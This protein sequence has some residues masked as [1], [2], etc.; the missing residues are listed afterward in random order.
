MRPPE[1]LQ[2]PVPLPRR[3]LPPAR[4]DVKSRR[5]RGLLVNRSRRAR[6]ALRK[7][8]TGARSRLAVRGSR[9]HEGGRGE[10]ERLCYQRRS[11]RGEYCCGSHC[12]QRFRRCQR[13]KCGQ[14]C[15]H[16]GG[17]RRREGR[18]CYDIGSSQGRAY[19]LLAKGQGQGVRES[20][21]SLW[22]DLRV[23]VF[24]FPRKAE[25]FLL[26]LSGIR[27]VHNRCNDLVCVPIM[28]P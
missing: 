4:E 15:E 12:G 14:V 1:R 2:L 6:G 26:L 11:E 7:A 10:E 18:E 21:R 9:Q 28:A 24:S 27:R 5:G 25:I 23:G 19:E 13:C 16:A 8:Q 3:P 20:P 17:F 22:Q